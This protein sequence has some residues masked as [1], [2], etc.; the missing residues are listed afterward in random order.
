MSAVTSWSTT[1]ASNN[2]SPPNGWPEGQAPSTV[3][4]CG[5]E[6]MAA[7]A[8]EA[9][10]NAVKVLNTISGA[11]TITAD[12]NPEL[13]AYATGMYVLFTPAGTNT[14]AVTLNIDG[15]GAKAVV[16][17]NNVALVAGDLKAAVPAF[18]MYDGTSFVLLNPL[19]AHTAN[20]DVAE[21][22]FK[23]A[24]VNDQNGSY[25]FVL[26]DAGKMVR[27]QS[28]AGDTYTIPPNSSVAF[29]VGTIIQVCN[30][31]TGSLALAR[32]AG[33]ALYIAGTGTDANVTITGVT[34]ASL[35]KTNTDEWCISGGGV[36]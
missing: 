26:S 18:C 9:Q 15:L 14:T 35:E 8:T 25:T 20:A 29:P 19:L 11:D 10:T 7:L 2:S 5:R 13:A 34:V 28:P 24:P 16:K 32:G 27:T 6:M 30:R 12:M 17:H 3:N 33:V 31:N 21:V 4:D 1:A 23:G 22:G 36:A